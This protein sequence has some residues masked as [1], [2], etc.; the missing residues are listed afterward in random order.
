MARQ[1]PGKWGAPVSLDYEIIKT[2]GRWEI[3]S[4][5]RVIG[6]CLAH[7]FSQEVAISKCIE[8]LCNTAAHMATDE[9]RR[10]LKESEVA[11]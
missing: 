3:W 9:R 10:V 1:Q 7:G 4:P 6:V 5:D 8:A 11:K 2:D